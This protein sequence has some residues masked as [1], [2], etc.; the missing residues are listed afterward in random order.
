VP[1]NYPDQYSVLPV[2]TLEI[3][4][5]SEIEFSFPESTSHPLLVI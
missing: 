5:A 2:L 1:I 4:R 3:S